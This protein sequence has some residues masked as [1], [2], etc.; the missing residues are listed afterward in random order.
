[1]CILI[2]CVLYKMRWAED[3]ENHLNPGSVNLDGSMD[4][5]AVR[6]FPISI[7][8]CV[9]VVLTLGSCESHSCPPTGA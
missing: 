8:S 3:R 6:L 1:M 4:G 9:G 2:R 7:F 5:L